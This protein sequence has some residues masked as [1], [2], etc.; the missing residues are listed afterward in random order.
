MAWEQWHLVTWNG[1]GRGVVGSFLGDKV[2]QHSCQIRREEYRNVAADFP[3][4]HSYEANGLG[5]RPLDWE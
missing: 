4:L 3:D 2:Q 5:V 1:S